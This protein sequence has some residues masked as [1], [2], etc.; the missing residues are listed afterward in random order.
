MTD[1]LAGSTAPSSRAGLESVAFSE[2]T[3]GSGALAYHVR[4]YWALSKPGVTRM[5]LLTAG[6]GAISAPGV[7][8][9]P[10][11]VA[12]VFGTALVVAG[13]NALNMFLERDSDALMTRT[14]S[15]PLPAGLLG[16][17]EALGFGVGVALLGLVVLAHFAS[18]LAVGTA[19]LALISYVLVYTPLKRVGPVA[20]Y[21]GAVPGALP[22]VIGYV[23][24]SGGFD[25]MAFCLFAI[26]FAW[27]IPH[28]LAISLFRA[29]EYGR[30]GLRVLP[31]VKGLDT[32]RWTLVVSA[33]LLLLTTLLPVLLGLAGLGYALPV[34]VVGAAFLLYAL[35]GVRGELDLLWARRV[36]F[37]S[38]PQL[39]LVF[40]ALVIAVV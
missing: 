16:P 4:Q 14:R 15:R 11:V 3:V 5:V 32:T 18:M 29:E 2:P 39:L 10:K 8:S 27:Q 25:R 20:L 26:L 12:I 35:T 37:A 7:V 19:A 24:V 38:M 34:G 30:A 6:L 23:G 36:F 33:F 22:P 1:S 40:A 28:F 9:W 13:A 31:V 21:V 17:D